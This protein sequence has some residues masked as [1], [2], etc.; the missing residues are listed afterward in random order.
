MEG[1][2]P[3]SLLLIWW[4]GSQEFESCVLM[5]EPGT[6]DLSLFLTIYLLGY[7][8]LTHTH[9]E[10]ED[11][12]RWKN[13]FTPSDCFVLK[14]VETHGS[15]PSV[16]PFRVIRRPTNKNPWIPLDTSHWFQSK[17]SDMLFGSERL[18]ILHGYR[19]IFFS[20]MWVCL[21]MLG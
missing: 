10:R 21:K 19:S 3:I 5:W 14:H 20:T 6:R 11:G 9:M 15:P 17:M 7:P 1:L 12:W 16:P 8:I 2:I 4:M 13:T 18:K